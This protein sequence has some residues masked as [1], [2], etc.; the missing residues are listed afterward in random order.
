[1]TTRAEELAEQERWRPL[2]KYVDTP[3]FGWLIDREFLDPQDQV[4]ECD[5]SLL[6]MAMFAAAQT[7]YYRE[8][9]AARGVRPAELCTVESL[10]RL[11]VLSRS[12]VVARH[13]ELQPPRLPPGKWVWGTARSSGTTGVP[14]AVPMSNTCNAM[15]TILWQR[16][17]RWFRMDPQSTLADFRLSRELRDSTEPE[18]AGATDY[19]RRPNWKYL[20]QIFHTGEQIDASVSLPAER[21]LAILRALRPRHLHSYPGSLEEIALAAKG[22]RPADSLQGVT[23]VGS[24]L[25]DPLR[26]WMEGVYQLPVHQTYGLN[27]IGKVAVRCEAGRY[28]VH[29]EHCLVEII[30]P[31]GR[32]CPAG[33][34]GHIVITSLLNHA[35]PLFR[36]DTGDLAEAVDTPCPCGRTLPSFTNIA[37][38][39]RRY[40]GLP[41]GTR[42]AVSDLIGELSKLSPEELSFLRGYQLFQ[43]RDNNYTLRLRVAAAIPEAFERAMRAIWSVSGGGRPLAIVEMDEIPR[44]PSGKHLD[45]LSEFYQDDYARPGAPE[46]ARLDASPP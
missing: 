21:Q 17:A 1:M 35:M 18:P 4:K 13:A 14:V 45:F 40:H 27:E 38:R 10:A 9:F 20:G 46:A 2:P 5:R 6:R 29:A 39:Y 42:M 25:T 44:S 43:D 15:Y 41:A 33:Q 37:G 11:P 23:A 16:Q 36:Y 32:P 34:T 31:D 3:W 28:H 30:D 26:G 7:P 22:E 24:Q 8:L 12:E 19:Q